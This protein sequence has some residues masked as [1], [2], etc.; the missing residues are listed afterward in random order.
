MSK[1]AGQILVMGIVV[2]VYESSFDVVVPEFGI[3][4]RVHGDQLPLVKAEFDKSKRVLELYWEKGV[5]S[6]TYV[7]PDERS[8][9][10]YRSSIK[11]KYRT[12]ALEAAKIQH[13]TMVEKNTIAPVSITDKLAAMNIGVPVF[14]SLLG[15]QN[16]E[17]TQKDD[18]SPYLRDCITR[19]EGNKYIQEIRELKQV[20]VLLRAEIGMSLPCL[21][22]RV[23]NPFAE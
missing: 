22:V 15:Q 19:V 3:E 13:S 4:K 11:N 20:P 2:Q 6:A 9:L 8:S 17:A 1:H 18:L 7:P 16:F 12:S 14:L 23:L 21:T 10:S 5:D